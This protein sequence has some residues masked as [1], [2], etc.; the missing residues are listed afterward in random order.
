MTA[1][2]GYYRPGE[3]S[4]S[5]LESSNF[6]SPYVPPPH[7]NQTGLTAEQADYISGYEHQ[8][9]LDPSLFSY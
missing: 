9:D 3:S 2:R 6:E 7:S 1:S 5:N 4:S 8:H